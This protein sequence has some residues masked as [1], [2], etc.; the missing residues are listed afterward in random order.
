VEGITL[1]YVLMM[2]EYTVLVMGDSTAN[3]AM[4]R[5]RTRVGLP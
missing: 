1:L 5:K 3:L 2:A 4:V